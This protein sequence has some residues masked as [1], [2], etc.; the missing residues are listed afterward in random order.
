MVF[1]RGPLAAEALGRLTANDLDSLFTDA[2][3]TELPL[4]VAKELTLAELAV[5]C[6][7]GEK[8]YLNVK[9]VF[10]NDRRPVR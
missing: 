9:H 10:V 6:G 7:A 4:S 5:K 1:G 8:G 3:T 2:H